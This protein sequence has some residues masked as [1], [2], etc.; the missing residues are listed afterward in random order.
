MCSHTSMAGTNHMALKQVEK[1]IQSYYKT[2]VRET[3]IFGR[4]L[5]LIGIC[6]KS[7]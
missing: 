4:L 1:E 6:L 7:L 3:D 5:A 2:E